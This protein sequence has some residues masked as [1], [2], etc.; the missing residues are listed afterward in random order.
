[1]YAIRSYYAYVNGNLVQITPEIVGTVTSIA[2][3]DGDFVQKGQVLV[4]FDN[5]DADIAFDSAEANLAQSVRQVRALFNN[6]EQAKAVVAE[7]KI[8]LRKAQSDLIRR[9]N[10]V[11]A[12][13]LSQEELS[14]AQDMMNS[15]EK[16]LAV[17]QQ[18]LNSYNFV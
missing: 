10:M 15:A 11:K 12:G 9:Q 17:A 16:A 7:Q 13:G 1:M 18:Q 2:A 14:H 5:S 8:G 6:V 4:H 3:D